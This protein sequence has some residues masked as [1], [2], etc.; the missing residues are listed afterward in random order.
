[1]LLNYNTITLDSFD[2]SK[3]SETEDFY[4]EI[5]FYLSILLLSSSLLGKDNI[6][7]Y[8]FLCNIFKDI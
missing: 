2:L 5:I 1:M 4:D 8:R 6:I 7:N 3:T